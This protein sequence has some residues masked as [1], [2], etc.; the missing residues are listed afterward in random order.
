MPPP[1]GSRLVRAWA[2]WLGEGCP[3]LSLRDT[4]GRTTGIEGTHVA[5]HVQRHTYACQL[6]RRPGATLTGVQ[7]ALG[8]S[9]LVTTAIYL[10]AEPEHL[11]R[12]VQGEALSLS[13]GEPAS[14]V[15]G[16]VARW[17]E[18]LAGQ[19][20]QRR[21]ALMAALKGPRGTPLRPGTD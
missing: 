21:E 11:R 12:V 17:A 13:K 2:G 9:R 6:L 20:G 4:A 7:L 5:P 1:A 10:H 3:W 14:A 15:N 8:H 16:A 19:T 18:A